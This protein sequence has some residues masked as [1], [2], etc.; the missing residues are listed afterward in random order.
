MPRF[1]RMLLALSI[2]S[3]LVACGCS[4]KQP[5]APEG[6][7]PVVPLKL[8]QPLSVLA[9]TVLKRPLVQMHERMGEPGRNVKLETLVIDELVA[10]L[11][12][13]TAKADVLLIPSGRAL[14]AA[15]ETGALEGEPT[16]PIA[17][18][19]AV[20]TTAQG[21]GVKIK[22][23]EDLASESVGSIAV[24]DPAYDAAA[25]LFMD[26]IEARGLLEAVEPKIVTVASP[27]AG[28]QA[29]ADGEADAGVSY[30]PSVMFGGHS[31]TCSIA[32]FLPKELPHA[33]DVVAVKF[34]G[35][36]DQV[37]AYLTA[38]NSPE[39]QSV[40]AC[41]GFEPTVSKDRGDAAKTLLIPCGAGL[42]PAMDVIGK[43]YYE[44]TGVRPDF[45][46]AGSGMLLATLDFTRRGDL[47]MPGE[48][49]WVTMAEDRDLVSD[50]RPV[51]YFTP[52]IAVPKGN[53][54]GIE[55]LEDLAKPGVRVA[56]GDPQALAIGPVTQR[57]LERAGIKE[58][59]DKNVV[60]RGGCIPELANCIS[61][62]GADACILWDAVAEQHHEKVDWVAIDPEQNEVAEVLIA[63]LSCA[64]H[65]EEAA[66]FM[67][68][69]A[70]EEASA[71][72]EREGFRTEPPEGIRIAPREGPDV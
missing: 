38:L 21:S 19:I 62:K 59:V 30:L 5:A 56:I 63:T 2:C 52:V 34:A 16:E 49:F 10:K 36:S 68:F 43:V 28:M 65:P 12:D 24:A 4:K 1:V 61:M 20:V 33:A 72:F 50:S 70:S 67:E 69:I 22:A 48:A 45:S 57:I 53:P 71:I 3:A 47:Y 66:D 18:M 40:L 17:R 14:E 13:G 51:V 37:D 35:A 31:G 32:C 23:L 11:K 15:L 58:A 39:A 64:A 9:P 6:F 42:Q 41:G 7:S 26:A 60:M 27:R 8:A 25:G 44:R 55:S 54:G 29:V 46:Y